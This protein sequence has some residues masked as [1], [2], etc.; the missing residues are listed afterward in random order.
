MSD[1]TRPEVEA[2]VSDYLAML[3]MELRGEPFNK[4]A[5]NRNLQRLLSARTKGSIE[6]KHQNISA[7]LI[8]LGYP[9]IDGYKPLGNYQELLS[10]V[11]VERVASANT[12]EGTLASL[13]LSP[14]APTAPPTDILRMEIPIPV[15]NRAER[16]SIYER[17]PIIRSP[18]RRNYL[19][20]EAR[21]TALGLAGERLVIQFEHE[22]L[23]RSGRRALADRIAH[24]SVTQG[25]GLGYD[26]LSYETD[27]R[28]RLIEV[29]TTRFGPLTP[30][31]ASR[32]E[33][34][35]SRS[36]DTTFSLPTVQI[37]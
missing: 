34:E 12:L 6:R 11:V 30:F 26:I 2:A 28:D 3:D 21:N 35:T 19:E 16:S 23:R 10:E 7:I 22:R 13:V 37:L 5:H 36:H 25:D 33:V 1:W 20:I 9:Y 15:P 17:P 14:P 32:N 24:V 29:K 4:A 18:S 31:F 8:E 27:G